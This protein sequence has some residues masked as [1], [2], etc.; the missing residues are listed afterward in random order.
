MEL[1]LMRWSSLTRHQGHLARRLRTD[2]AA[3]HCAS[4]AHI[5]DLT[6]A[7]CTCGW[8]GH[9][10]PHSRAGETAAHLE[11]QGHLE[12]VDVDDDEKTRRE[13][14]AVLERLSRCAT[15]LREGAIPGELGILLRRAEALAGRAT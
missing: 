13:L 4:A 14:V 5:D 8:R 1:V 6:F 10:F 15:D 12:L 3:L 9:S 11:W 2:G 7:H